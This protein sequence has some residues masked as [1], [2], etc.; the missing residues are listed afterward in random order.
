[1]KSKFYYRNIFRKITKISV[2]CGVIIFILWFFYYQIKSE[3]N[4]VDKGGTYLRREMKCLDIKEI[5]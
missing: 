1:M 4:C 2:I 5:K 3:M